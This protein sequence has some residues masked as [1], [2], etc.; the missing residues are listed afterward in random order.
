M[1]NIN[2]LLKLTISFFLLGFALWY[3]NL[4]YN[5]TLILFLFGVLLKE[6]I[7]LFKFAKQQIAF[8]FLL[9]MIFIFQSVNGYGKILLQ[10][11]FL[12]LNVTDQGIKTASIFVSQIIL[13]FLIF[14]ITIYSIKRQEIF[15]YFGKLK[16][17][18]S[19]FEKKLQKLIQIGLFVFYLLPTSF[20]DQKAISV[21]VKSELNKTKMGLK[22]KVELVFL[23][24]YQFFFRILKSAEQEYPV[25]I[26][27]SKKSLNFS[28]IPL[29]SAQNIIIL[30][31]I[32]V[33][34]GFLLWY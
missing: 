20:G 22:Q 8:A 17:S 3:Q 19:M 11:P 30:T 33:S 14:G 21:N 4:I 1:R 9:L 5:I 12:N 13:I 6:N 24:I 34:H 28:P 18:G 32:F 10:L 25:F 7:T 23:G 16:D 15:F 26:K 29:Y 31:I 2:F 27:E